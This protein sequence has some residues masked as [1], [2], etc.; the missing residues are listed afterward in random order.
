MISIFLKTALLLGAVAGVF[1]Q[2]DE[3]PCDN[4]GAYDTST[5]TASCNGISV[6]FFDLVCGGGFSQSSCVASW[7]NSGGQE[8]DYFFMGAGDGIDANQLPSECSSSFQDTG[9][10]MVQYYPG[11]SGCYPAADLSGTLATYTSDG[12]SGL[13]SVTLNFA[14]HDDGSNVR[15]GYIKIT[16][17]ATTS[18]FTTDGDSIISSKYEVKVDAP[19][20]SGPSPPPPPGPP[21]PNPP[22]PPGPPGPGPAT[23]PGPGG[24]SAQGDDVGAILTIVFFVS[25][26]MYFSLGF[27]YMWKVKHAEGSD[28]IP[29][30]EF[31]TG[32][33]GLVKEGFRFTKA[34]LTKSD[35]TPL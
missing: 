12:G 31:W 11:G 27:V 14:E 1:S 20:G 16:C 22:P 33:P 24:Q 19:C 23:T 35:Y 15:A 2:P 28:R 29:N 17:S 13:Q 25:L 32:L 3:T 6:N 4:N 21:G 30:K 18:G 26:L 10:A 8:E 34:K 9:L 7:T 5:G